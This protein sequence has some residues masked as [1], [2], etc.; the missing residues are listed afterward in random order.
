MSIKYCVDC[1]WCDRNS[2]RP[3]LSLCR[4]PDMRLVAINADSG[5]PLVSPDFKVDIFCQHARRKEV[6]NH[7][8]G[9]CG[10][11][12]KFFEQRPPRAA[13]LQRVAALVGM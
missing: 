7:E 11:D 1:K 3:D 2:G 12:A 6:T 10:P 8:F 9:A 4:Q 5:A 13:F